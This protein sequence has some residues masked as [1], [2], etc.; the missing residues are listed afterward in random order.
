ME[1]I[2]Y[3]FNIP[4]AERV[5]RLQRALPLLLG[6]SSRRKDIHCVALMVPVLAPQRCIAKMDGDRAPRGRGGGSRVRKR[7]EARAAA[8]REATESTDRTLKEAQETARHLMRWLADEEGC[9]IPLLVTAV[10]TPQCWREM[11]LY[12]TWQQQREANSC[13]PLRN[14]NLI[15]L[16]LDA[17]NMV[18]LTSSPPTVPA[19]LR[20]LGDLLLLHQHMLLD[21][22]WCVTGGRYTQA[23]E[24][25]RRG[26]GK[27][28]MIGRT[29]FDVVLPQLVAPK[30]KVAVFLR[31]G[32]VILRCS[33]VGEKMVDSLEAL[34][35]GFIEMQHRIQDLYNS[36]YTAD[37][38]LGKN[39]KLFWVSSY[40]CNVSSLISNTVSPSISSTGEGNPSLSFLG[41]RNL[42]DVQALISIMMGCMTTDF[43]AESLSFWRRLLGR[44]KIALKPQCR[45]VVSSASDTHRTHKRAKRKRENSC[46]RSHASCEPRQTSVKEE[47]L[48]LLEW[49]AD[50]S[51]PPH[52][53]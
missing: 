18:L 52:P 39:N 42:R 37:G 9:T 31:Y 32:Q 36:V 26:M 44:Q 14:A 53:V 45:H 11:D 7:G 6:D 49:S 5:E 23:M 35:D 27:S 22:T 8:F 29:F 30:G 10:L 19:G 46:G 17:P 21:M 3:E 24:A 16:R 25:S 15:S 33:F 38:G 1:S 40:G 13:S 20:H 12:K 48:E 4:K 47:P 34:G 51:C 50:L 43:F 41:L 28:E 2:D